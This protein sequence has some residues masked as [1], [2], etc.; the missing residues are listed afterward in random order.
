MDTY[1]RQTWVDKRL[2]FNLSVEVLV[3]HISMLELLWKPDTY[4]YNGMGSYLHT[5]TT[6]NKLLRIMKNG[7][8]FYSTRSGI[9]RN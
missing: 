9:V 6:P 3:V 8:V 4:F 7:T 1:F 2:K 5:I